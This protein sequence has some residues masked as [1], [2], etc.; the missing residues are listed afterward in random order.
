[1]SGKDEAQVAGME[2]TSTLPAKKEDVDKL[3][4]LKVEIYQ[5]EITAQHVRNYFAPKDAT[6]ADIGFFIAM[7]NSLGLNPWKRELHLIPFYS[8]DGGRKYAAVVGYEVYLNRAEASGKLA[9]W[10]YEYDNEDAPTKCTVTVYRKDWPDHPFKHTVYMEDVIKYKGD[11]AKGVVTAMWRRQGRFQLLK[12]TVTQTFRFCLPET[13][14]SLPYIEDELTDLRGY[15]E[16]L[17]APAL[18]EAE[19]E[20]VQDAPDLSSLRNKYF[21]KIDGMFADNDGR[22]AW[23]LQATG[24]ASITEWD[25]DDYEKAFEL[26]RQIPIDEEES[27]PDESD[28]DQLEITE[29]FAEAI[30]ESAIDVHEWVVQ[31]PVE[32]EK[33]CADLQEALKQVDAGDN[34]SIDR[35]HNQ[36]TEWK[37]NIDEPGLC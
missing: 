37:K 15:Q 30:S 32:N 35:L 36:F 26:L 1:M 10:E 9:G 27:E 13:C 14:G 7:A 11:P 24:K 20:S 34:E 23:Q 33:A 25:S 12:C 8:K 18:E 2:T 22:H 16:S 31:S 4:A 21:K 28:T 19:V 5:M 17:P 29:A 3:P 6:T